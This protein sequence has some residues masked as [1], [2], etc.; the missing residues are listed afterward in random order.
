[1]QWF[2]GHLPR[3]AQVV[4]RCRYHHS[5]HRDQ[6]LK[7]L[8]RRADAALKAE[9]SNTPVDDLLT[10]AEEAKYLSS[11]NNNA[12]NQMIALSR[13]DE[14]LERVVRFFDP[15]SSFTSKIAPHA[16]SGIVALRIGHGGHD[17]ARNAVRMII[18][19][20]GIKDLTAS[21]TDLLVYTA[22]RGDS[23]SFRIVL[24][25]IV[26]RNGLARSSLFA[27][28]V[29]KNT[30]MSII[31][32]LIEYGCFPQ[33]GTHY[34]L[35]SQ[36]MARE[37]KHERAGDQ[38]ITKFAKAV[39]CNMEHGRKV[40]QKTLLLVVMKSAGMASHE[41]SRDTMVRMIQTCVAKGGKAS[42]TTQV[43]SMII[44]SHR[45]LSV[46]R[47]E[48]ILSKYGVSV[49]AATKRQGLLMRRMTT[50]TFLKNRN[51]I[52]KILTMLNEIRA[53]DKDLVPIDFYT[54]VLRLVCH[55]AVKLAPELYSQMTTSLPS[56][57]Q[58]I[59]RAYL[60]G[61]F[62][63]KHYLRVIKHHYYMIRNGKDNLRSWNYCLSA[64][65]KSLRIETVNYCIEE[66]IAKRM[67]IQKKQ[68]A[69]AVVSYVEIGRLPMGHKHDRKSRPPG[70]ASSKKMTGTLAQHQPMPIEDIVRFIDLLSSNG[71]Y[72]DEAY[73]RWFYDQIELF[74]LSY[75]EFERLTVALAHSVC[76]SSS[77]SLS[78]PTLSIDTVDRL[79]RW[80]YRK[81]PARPWRVLELI[82][83]MKQ[84][85]I[86]FS[87]AEV[88]SAFS[89]YVGLVYGFESVQGEFKRVRMQ[90]S[91]DMDAVIDKINQ[92]WSSIRKS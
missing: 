79:I 81:S 49:S 54:Q 24:E 60:S 8:V 31:T 91:E 26:T 34:E 22:R 55:Q 1:M 27:K 9:P 35:I 48:D 15:K 84:M 64:A 76:Q 19:K 37:R 40:P 18:D 74:Q 5:G 21:F 77:S 20:Y 6:R 25:E 16:L 83:K 66:M 44:Q 65:A 7:A 56:H 62:H 41:M 75:H 87:D 12:V 10:N 80:G 29:D 67:F 4:R 2:K 70:F 71:Y 30:Q 23:R 68:V 28:I 61:L 90:S 69:D 38:I 14:Q 82:N 39:A 89:R 78:K 3:A 43:V 86:T 47:W 58:E 42:L 46:S 59:D 52:K 88:R 50:R 72:I 45:Y 33:N 53:G 17:S 57:V 73:W 63:S 85:G 51:G 11:L 36:R 32:V 13:S 92:V